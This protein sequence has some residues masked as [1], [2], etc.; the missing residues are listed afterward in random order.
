MKTLPSDLCSCH[1]QLP[2][3]SCCRPYHTG[4]PAPTALALMRSRFSA[5]ALG[6]TDYIMETTHPASFH[7]E[8]N[9][10]SWKKSLLQFSQETEFKNLKIWEFQE[11]K[12]RAVVTFTVFLQQ[13]EA[14]IFTE[15]SHFEKIKGRWLYLSGIIKEGE[16]PKLASKTATKLLPLA[17]YTH[18]ILRKKA[19]VISVIDDSIKTLVE[20]MIETM[21]AANGIGLAAPQVHHSIRLFI[22][23]TPIPQSD[24]TYEKGDIKVFINPKLSVPS[25]EHIKGNEGCLSI[26]R[27]RADVNRPRVITVEYTNLKGETTTTTF[28]D[29]EARVIMHENDHINGTLFVDRLTPQEQKQF[30]NELSL[31]EKRLSSL[32]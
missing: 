6:L 21:D 2:Y 9:R 4:T 31:L 12:D 32:W 10:N 19:E 25:K 27:L 30:K 29:W 22:I 3:A 1:S 8:D 17:Y 15:R 23:R 24:G 20:E 11:Y 5:Y 14:V 13:Q 26:P 18:P 28:S 7:Y 16:V